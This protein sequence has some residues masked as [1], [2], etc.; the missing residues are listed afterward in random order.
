MKMAEFVELFIVLYLAL[1]VFK[2]KFEK[3]IKMAE[4]I[5]ENYILLLISWL[6]VSCNLNSCLPI[7]MHFVT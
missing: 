4:L 5:S 2:W 1:L 7:Q 3:D 6:Y